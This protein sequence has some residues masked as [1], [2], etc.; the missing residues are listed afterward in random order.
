MPISSKLTN[1]LTTHTKHLTRANQITTKRPNRLHSNSLTNN[2]HNY[3]Q[4]KHAHQIKQTHTP[5]HNRPQPTTN[6][7]TQTK[8][9]RLHPTQQHLL[10]LIQ[11]QTPSQQLTN[12]IH[13]NTHQGKHN[14]RSKR[15]L[16]P[17]TKTRIRTIIILQR[18]QQT[19]QKTQSANT[20][21]KLV[22][23]SKALD[24]TH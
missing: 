10:H 21:H 2:Q 23:L 19:R 15:Q 6:P 17:N 8:R 11:R 22:H 7:T 14:T 9:R 12:I 3:L 13:T 16:Q 18:H 20:L 4:T 24:A 1:Q 5:L